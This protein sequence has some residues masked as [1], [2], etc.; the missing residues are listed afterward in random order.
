MIGEPGRRCDRRD[1]PTTI[2]QLIRYP[3]KLRLTLVCSR[4]DANLAE[5][6]AGFLRV[7]DR[8]RQRDGIEGVILGGTELPLLLREPTHSVP[9]LDTTQ[10]H[11]DAV[12]ARAMSG[13]AG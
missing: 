9:F 12:V 7:I 11:V 3:I 6:R 5:T 4:A 1:R 13:A 8:L 10:I 2:A